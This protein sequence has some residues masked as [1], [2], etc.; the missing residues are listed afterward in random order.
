MTLRAAAAAANSTAQPRT[1]LLSAFAAS[2]SCCCLMSQR[3]RIFTTSRVASSPRI[4]VEVTGRTA[5][6]LA[7]FATLLLSVLT[8]AFFRKRDG[9]PL[10]VSARVRGATAI[11]DAG[12]PS[13]DDAVTAIPAAPRSASSPC[14]RSGHDA[15]V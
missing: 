1:V 2:S 10:T 14:G 11:D 15:E 8:C 6:M 7:S 3:S 4:P 5:G 12:P 13:D 9:A